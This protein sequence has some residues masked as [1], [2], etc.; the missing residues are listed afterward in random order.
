MDM[1]IH[2]PLKQFKL[3]LCALPIQHPKP[4]STETMEPLTPASLMQIR[5]VDRG[6]LEDCKSVNHG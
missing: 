1:K 6:L 5:M 3:I 4:H 2:N